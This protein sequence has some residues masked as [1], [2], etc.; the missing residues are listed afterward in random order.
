[1]KRMM[2][3]TMVDAPS[4]PVRPLG[5]TEPDTS[6]GITTKAAAEAMTVHVMASAHD[7]H[8]HH[9]SFPKMAPNTAPTTNPEGA[10]AP[11]R[12]KTSV[13]LSPLGYTRATRATPLGRM[14]AGLMP[15]MART[16]SK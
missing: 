4:H 11:K 9:V 14:V 10:V 12:A 3:T 7:A 5:L 2:P 13:F 6:S 1:M 15:C 8:G 16:T